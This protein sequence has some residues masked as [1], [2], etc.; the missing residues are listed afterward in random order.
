MQQIPADPESPMT[1]SIT[2]ER[3]IAKKVEPD[4]FRPPNLKLRKDI[5]IKLAEL[6]KE[7]QS[8]F[9]N[10]ETITGTRPL[11]DMMIDTGVSEPVSQKTYPLVMKHYKWVKGEINK[12]LTAKLIQ[13][14]PSS[15]SGPIIVVPKGDGG[16]HLVIDYCALNK[17]TQK[18]IWP[19]PK[20]EDIFVQLNDM[21]YFS[22]PICEQDITPSH[23]MSHQYPKQP[24]PH[25]LENMNMPRCSLS[26]LKH[27]HIFRNS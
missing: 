13:G 2:T 11:M 22:T 1:H 6:L 7:Y 14:S 26:L 17:I 24:S 18:F 3:M 21:K 8:Q 5:E 25:H 4:T 23:W 16:K 19:M 15:W 10:D 20:I 12:L 9:A 27:L